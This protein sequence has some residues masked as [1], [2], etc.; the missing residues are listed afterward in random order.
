MKLHSFCKWKIFFFPVINFG[1]NELKEVL[2]QERTTGILSAIPR[3]PS[4]KMRLA[5]N[6]CTENDAISTLFIHSPTRQPRM[7]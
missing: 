5:S 2:L 1:G 6:S 3:G 4:P 7:C